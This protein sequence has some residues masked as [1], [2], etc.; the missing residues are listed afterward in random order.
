MLNHV[1]YSI[2]VDHPIRPIEPLPPLPNIPRGSLLVVEGRAP[3]WRYGM[4][5]HLLHGSPAAAIAFYDPRL[6]AVIVASHNPSFTI[7]QVVDVTI[8]EEK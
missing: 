7:G 4:A 1:V 2:G 8:P 5:L 6:G 3:I